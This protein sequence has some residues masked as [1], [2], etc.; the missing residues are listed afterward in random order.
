MSCM[1]IIMIRTPTGTV[2]VQLP[3]SVRPSWP[4]FLNVGDRAAGSVVL[5]NQTAA[6]LSVQIALRCANASIAPSTAAGYRV[7]VCLWRG[8]VNVRGCA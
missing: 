5:V 6:D 8:S 3:L 1:L 2:N 4:R 7:S